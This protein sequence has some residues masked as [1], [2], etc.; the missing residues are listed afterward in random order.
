MS[1]VL[2]AFIK[3]QTNR[4]KQRLNKSGINIIKA[5]SLP[6]CSQ[7]PQNVKIGIPTSNKIS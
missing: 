7:K 6:L 1:P 4:T 5:V 3:N 2:Y